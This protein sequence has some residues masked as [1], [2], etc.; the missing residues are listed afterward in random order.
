M[1]E[2]EREDAWPVLELTSRAR[3]VIGMKILF[4]VFRH[5]NSVSLPPREPFDLPSLFF[6]L[7]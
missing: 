4:L 6:S 3:T 1:T 5:S 2:D 7:H